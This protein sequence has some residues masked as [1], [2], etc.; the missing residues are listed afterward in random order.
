MKTAP[1]RIDVHYHI[2]PKPYVEA[3]TAKGIKGST[4]VRFP[5]WTPASAIKQLDRS[6]VA[7][8]MTSLST[9]GVWFGD[10]LLAR[11]LSRTCNEFQARMASDHPGRFGSMAFLPL[12]DVEGALTELEYA[13]DELGHDGVVLMSDVDGRYLGHPSYEELFAELDRRSAV[14]FIH[15]NDDPRVNRRNAIFSPLLEWPIHTTRAAMDLLYSGR[16]ARYPNIRYILAH[17]GGAVPYLAYRIAAGQSKGKEARGCDHGWEPHEEG[18]LRNGLQL[19]RNLFYDT[20]SPGKGHFAALKEF[21]GPGHMLFGT[22]GGWT[23]PIQTSLGIK[24]LVSFDGFTESDL[25]AIEYGSASTLFPRFEPGPGAALGSG[26]PA[27]RSGSSRGAGPRREA[28]P[29]KKNVPSGKAFPE[30]CCATNQKG[31]P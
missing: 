28:D 4:Y 21:V 3:L 24:A 2:I 15:P 25:A 19:L 13:L 5:K 6:G 16:L 26:P 10:A 14:V 7:T 12:P 8:A 27:K 30:A 9:P 20:A 23:P 29:T 31:Q 11:S 18:E 22:D 17:G 1:H